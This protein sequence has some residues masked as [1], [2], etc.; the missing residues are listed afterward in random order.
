MSNLHLKGVYGSLIFI[1]RNLTISII[2]GKNDV[3]LLLWLECVREVHETK[4]LT[5][6]NHDLL[7]KKPQLTFSN[8]PFLYWIT[9]SYYWNNYRR[10][11]FFGWFFLLKVSHGLWWI[12]VTASQLT[13]ILIMILCV[14]SITQKS[15]KFIYFKFYKK[16]C[17]NRC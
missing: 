9:Q 10:I 12:C 13:N 5:T 14:N 8:N 16:N 1:K 17:N 4:V 2:K 3:I 6:V 15:F 11:F 7:I